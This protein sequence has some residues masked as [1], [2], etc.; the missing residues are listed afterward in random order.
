MKL[1]LFLL[2]DQVCA[3]LWFDLKCLKILLYSRPDEFPWVTCPQAPPRIVAKPP[4]P[5]NKLQSSGKGTL[6]Y[7]HTWPSS[8]VPFLVEGQHHFATPS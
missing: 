8:R 3:R 6:K 1:I 2:L 4:A 5:E 7:Y